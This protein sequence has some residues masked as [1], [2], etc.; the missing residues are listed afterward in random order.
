MLRIVHDHKTDG[1][2]VLRLAGQIRGEWVAALRQ[3]C[4]DVLREDA[5][6]SLTL[7]FSD[8]A[9][10]DA[11]GLVL[12]AELSARGVPLINCSLFAAQQLKGFADVG[13]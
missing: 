1:A 2:V 8:V 4:D 11:A 10:M 6:P 5:A 3:A 12:C 9:F 13:H 7:D